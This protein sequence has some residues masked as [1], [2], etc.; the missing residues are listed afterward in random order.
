VAGDP[1]VSPRSWVELHDGL[2]RLAARVDAVD[3]RSYETEP[4]Q[5]AAA[6]LA[7]GVTEL[8]HETRML[9]GVMLSAAEALHE[10]RG[11]STPPSAPA[12][13]LSFE[14]ALD[15]ALDESEGWTL[16]TVCDVMFL[17]RLELAQ[18]DERLEQAVRGALQ[19][20]IVE[21]CDGALRRIRKALL[22]VDQALA[23]AD[24]APA[25]LDFASELETS[26]AVR[27]TY[28]QLR[29]RI[30]T[31]GEP[32]GN[33]LPAQLREIGSALAAV[34]GWRGYPTLRIRDRMQIRDLQRRLLAW[35]R[36]TRDDLEGERIWQD[37]RYFA[38]MLEHVNQR[39]ELKEHDTLVLERVW[40]SL[41]AP[42]EHEH[43]EPSSLSALAALE[44]LDDELDALLAS[45]RHDRGAWRAALGGRLLSSPDHTSL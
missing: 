33:R 17:V 16:A 8:L 22:T 5:S 21:E 38:E 6:E 40:Q 15:A 2:A 37:I 34:V 10:E 25:K 44:G 13:N 3:I 41:S 23:R 24:L 39:Q 18:R 11:G 26:L 14:R 45:G 36:T 7:T 1:L 35:F 31:V 9:V 29:R 12:A 42:S 20:R 30:R 28:G 19:A 43:V 32:A 27:R 4:G